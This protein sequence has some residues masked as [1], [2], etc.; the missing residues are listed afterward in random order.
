MTCRGSDNFGLAGIGA[1]VLLLVVGCGA[2]AAQPN[3][4]SASPTPRAGA[5][6][7]QHRPI[8][9]D[10]KTRRRVLLGYSV[11][12]RRITAY[13]VGD[14]DSSRRVL[15]VGCIHGNERAG[16]AIARALTRVSP[17]QDVDLWIVPMLNP[18]GAAAGTRTNARGVDLNRNFPYQWRRNGSRGSLTYPG[19][20]AGSEPETRL[21]IALL[22]KV[23]PSL[24]IWY[25]QALGVVD[26]SQGP[27]ALERR[28]AADVQMSLRKLTDYPG[29]AVGQEDHRFGPTAFVVELPGGALSTAAVHRHEQA[30]LDLAGHLPPG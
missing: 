4:P 3:A 16:V 19:P 20:R 12:H 22:N 18:D 9:T 24:A 10:L 21:A 1:L 8:T 25:H 13:E 26:N 14:P 11:D 23:R 15:V 6:S 5:S 17:T 2:H 29:S 30:I 7:V 27:R 28:Y